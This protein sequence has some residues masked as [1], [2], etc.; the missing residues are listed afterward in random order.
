MPDRRAFGQDN[1]FRPGG[2][3]L[4]LPT[5]REILR[6]D[7]M[8][9]ALPEVL[10]GEGGLDVLVRWV[11]VAETADVARLVS[12][13]ELLLATG[14]GWPRDARGLRSLGRELAEAE[15]AG[16]VLELGDR[17]PV[18]PQP[19]V[20]EFRAAGLPF[21]VLHREARFVA[22]TEAVHAR[23]ID[24]QTVAL[25]ARDEIRELFTGLSLRGSPADFIVA[26]AARALGCPV[27]LEDTGHQVLVA[28]NVGDGEAELERWEQR[29]RAAHRGVGEPG[30]TLTPVEA[31][32]MRWGHL[33]ALPGEPH[34]AGRSS[35]LE[36]AAVA[37]ALSRLADRD[38]DEWIRRSHDALLAALLGRRFARDG[39]MAARFEAAGF[40]VAG[41]V[42]AGVAVRSRS[43]RVEEGAVARAVEAATAVGALAIAAAHPSAPG[44]LVL[45]VSARAGHSAADAVADALARGDAAVVGVGSDARGI[46]GL[47][48][49]IEEAVELSGRGAGG[50]GRHAVVQRA[51][52]R[53][54]LRLVT[55]FGDDPR[56]QEYS[57]RMLRPLI[58]YDFANDGDLVEVL[59]AYLSHPGNRTRAAAA[60]HLSRSVFYQRIALIED[61]LGLDLDDGE[62]IGA[63]HTAVLARRVR[64]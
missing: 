22:I 48:S 2:E 7:P 43:G 6:M 1:T 55:A 51:E 19:L 14:L 24:D 53:P 58:E 10:A 5:V 57:E 29:S 38:D 59:R 23:I 40:P 27:V 52:S 35:V 17:T 15:I 64:G 32:G 63:L 45:A 56:L 31:R 30:W 16:L 54:L 11:H 50:R 44:L 4:L 42:L 34:P 36:Q 37:L 62:T 46:P 9:D 39:G 26:Q 12:G 20:D 8:A 28:E 41:R 18:A 25:R 21:V 13:G 60:S 49:S 33:V 61:L 3:R 47:L